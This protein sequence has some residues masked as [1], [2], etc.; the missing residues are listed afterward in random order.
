VVSFAAA[1]VGDP[2][3]A[4][5]YSQAFPGHIRYENHLDIVPFLPPDKSFDEV[6]EKVP[7]LGKLFA[8]AAQWDYVP[9][10]VLQ[11]IEASGDVIDDNPLLQAVRIAEILEKLVSLDLSAIAAAHSATGGYD[12]G[13]CGDA[14]S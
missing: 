2:G 11:Y 6:A 1:H 7:F 5:H 13:A 12:K 14:V 10:G 3:F 9:A 4:D 8:L